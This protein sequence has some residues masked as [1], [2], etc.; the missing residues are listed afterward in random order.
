[1]PLIHALP[2][3]NLHAGKIA[4]PKRLIV[5]GNVN[6]VSGLRHVGTLDHPQVK[7][8]DMRHRAGVLGAKAL[9][10]RSLPLLGERLSG[11]RG[12]SSCFGIHDSTVLGG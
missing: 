7:C 10:Q 8:G 4:L 9:F 1:M 6:G 3:V 5:D 2:H 11:Q 12:V